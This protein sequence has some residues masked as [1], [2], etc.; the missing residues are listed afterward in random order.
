MTDYLPCDVSPHE[1][2]YIVF[3][4]KTAK[5]HRQSLLIQNWV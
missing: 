4:K 2:S 1:D 3:Q 5:E